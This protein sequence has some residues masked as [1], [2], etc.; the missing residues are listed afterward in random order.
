[1]LSSSAVTSVQAAQNSNK[2]RSNSNET[3]PL[4][5]INKTPP[6]ATIESVNLDEE[7]KENREELD[8]RE[9]VTKPYPGVDD[10]FFATEDTDVDP[11]SPKPDLDDIDGH[12]PHPEKPHYPLFPYAPGYGHDVEG[13]IPDLETIP[14][15]NVYQH[16]KT[17]AQG[18]MD[19]AL[20]SANANQL[21][22]VLESYNRHPYFY[23]SIVLISISLF[24]QVAV[25]I[26]LIWNSRYNVK[27]Q[28]EICV[29]NRINNFTVMGIFLITIVNVFVSAFGVANVE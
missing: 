18:M 24:L 2:H 13:S 20:F 10:G 4:L 25:G 9:T 26:G 5:N 19:L 16:K 28:I 27:N 14:D 8:D 1:M 7:E 23:P 17:L 21:R 15:V 12:I 6:L 29:A 22:Y 3:L 11:A